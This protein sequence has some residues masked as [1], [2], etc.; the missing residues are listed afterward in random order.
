MGAF[1]GGQGRE[2]HIILVC[3]RNDWLL[4]CTTVFLGPGKGS[5]LQKKVGCEKGDGVRRQPSCSEAAGGFATW[6]N[7]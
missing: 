5:R 6:Q 4:A 3:Q 2:D 7:I 1:E